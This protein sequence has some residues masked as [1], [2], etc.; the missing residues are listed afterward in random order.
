MTKKTKGFT[1][2][3]LIVGIAV[4]LVIIVAVYNAYIG[5]FNVVYAS[6]AKIEAIALVNEQLEIARNLPYSDVGEVSGIP[7]GKLTHS[8]TITRDAYQYNVLT[9]VRNV[10]DPF[11]GTLGGVPNDLSPSD[12]KIVEIEISCLS[13]V[14]PFTPIVITTRVAPKNLETASNNGALFVRVFDA[15]GNPV[16]DASVHIENNTVNPAIIIDDS[17]N[18]NGLLQVVDAPPGVN[19]YEITVTKSGFST[20]KTY[21]ATVPNPHPTKPFATVVLQQVTQLSFI[22]DKLS[23]FAVSSVTNTCTPVPGIDFTLLGSKT[24][25][26]NPIVYKYNQS[27]VTNGSGLLSLPNM[28]WDAYTLTNTDSSYDLIGINPLSPLSLSPNSGQNVQLVVAPKNPDTLLVTVHDSVTGLPLSGVSVELT[29]AGYDVTESTGQGFLGQTDW[30]G[31][32]GQATSTDL[33]KYFASD[34]NIETQLPIG[35]VVLKKIS[36][37]YVSNGNLT[38]SS[39][40]TGSANNFGQLNWNPHDEPVSVG[41]PNVRVQIATN[42]DGGTW[43][44]TGP[45][46]T[47]GTYYTNANK[48]IAA[49][50]NGRRYLRYKLFLDSAVTNA[51][52]NISDLSFTFTSQCTPPGQVSFSG[53]SS[54][55]YNLHMTKD[56]YNTQDVPVDITSAWQSMDIVFAPL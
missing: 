49:G 29:K 50:N 23:S 6:R 42:N 19:A 11:D 44:F 27:L 16:P 18:S 4:F 5:V 30:S 39:Y 38:S 53:L 34:G 8:Q 7:N 2:V 15:N 14:K 51:T 46:G 3:E 13:C 33:T 22:I 36:G 10:D 45:D 17:T 12:Y 21:P 41:T 26:T 56:G 52:P 25:G 9:T 24:I 20:D 47:A 54:G 40:D 43:N 28:E 31:G 55:T 1:L 48:N 35:D 37:S 32:S